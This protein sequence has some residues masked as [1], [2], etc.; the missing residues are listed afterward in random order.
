MKQAAVTA[1]IDEQNNTK[2][3]AHLVLNEQATTKHLEYSLFYFAASGAY[4]N[5]PEN[6]YQ[7]YLESAQYADRA[8]FKAVWTPERHF[9]HVGGYYPNPVVLNAALATITKNIELR[10]GSV[11]LPLH[12]PLRVVEEWSVVDNLSGGRV[13]IA[14]A[15]GW[16]PKDFAFFPDRYESRKKIMLEYIEQVK[17]LWCGES[18]TTINGLGNKNQIEIF[19]KPKQK[20]LPIWLTAA[21]DRNTFIEAGKL[22]ANLLTH[23]LGQTIDDLAEKISLYYKALTAHG[24][25]RRQKKVTL[26]LHT[27]VWNNQSEAIEICR[28]PFGEYLRSH[29]SLATMA[30]S[31]GK[32]TQHYSDTEIDEIINIALERYIHTASL[33]GS[34][35]S[36]L[37]VIKKLKGR[38]V[39]EIACLIDFGV[40]P[41]LVLKSFEYLDQLN[42]ES[43]KIAVW[44]NNEL[45]SYLKD[46][47]PVYMLPKALVTLDR[48][49]LTSS[50]KVDKKS[51]KLIE[52]QHRSFYTDTQY[53][54]PSTETEKTLEKIW[55]EFLKISRIGIQDNFFEL[56]GHSLLALQ[57]LGKVNRTFN[58]HLNVRSIFDAPTIAKFAVI[59]DSMLVNKSQN[60]FDCLIALKP[61]GKKNPLFLIH[62]VG[63]TIF[64]YSSLFKYLDP[65]RPLYAIQDPGI[66]SGENAIPF[67]TMEEMASFYIKKIHAVQAN[68]PYLIGGASSGANISVEMACQL[69]KMGESVA[70][71][72]LLDGWVPYPDLL[73]NQEFF[74]T[75]MR[76]QYHDMQEKFISKGIFRSEALLKLQWYRLQMYAKYQTPI[77]DFKLT[78][79]KAMDTIPI[80]QS[81][82]DKF[83]HWEHYSIQPI[84][85]FL[86]PGDHETMFQEPNVAVLGKKLNQCLN[87]SEASYQEDRGIIHEESEE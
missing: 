1:H 3:V 17:K 76:R 54:S 2:L 41:H 68:G 55:L 38:G 29:V 53:V 60:D 59:V 22:G 63:G 80:Y 30:D 74:E 70:F 50:G 11:V 42:K 23:L 86:V 19:P 62:P 51:L 47:L 44:D 57:V 24:H 48:L 72:G 49:P 36:C 32:N 40:E 16:N 69:Q 35:D 56:G 78:L 5:N 15:S 18:F 26:M 82:E 65:A 83:N 61:N 6:P 75:N 71:I 64:W 77:I 87:E 31:L 9:H 37:E 79:F 13:G 7:F 67:Q 25:D 8:G 73:M 12:N 45:M 58:I 20:T 43:Q 27:F 46:Y 34:V 21:G 33:I 66:E 4:H 28:K 84:K 39:D 85:R 10:A 81:V 14:F 52:P